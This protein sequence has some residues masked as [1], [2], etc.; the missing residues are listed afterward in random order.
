MVPMEPAARRGDAPL[1][2]LDWVR[3][4]LDL[5]S[6]V[7]E[8]VR[9]IRVEQIVGTAS[10]A[11][12]FDGRWRPRTS[13]LGKLLDDIAL[14]QPTGMDEPITVV[15][16]DRAYFVID[17]HKRVA[18]AHRTGREF[19]DA[20]VSHLPSPYVVEASLA[21]SAIM[22]T[23]RETEFRRHSRLI[24][25]VPEA[26]FA[27]TDPDA[28]GE[29]H[30]AVRLYG[31]QHPQATDAVEAARLWYERDYLPAVAYARAQGL[32]LID[33][34]TDADTYLA[35]H[36]QRLVLWGTECDAA[37][38]AADQVLAKRRLESARRGSFRDLLF[39]RGAPASEERLLL[40]LTDAASSGA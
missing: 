6:P 34:C 22:R 19:L 2:E 36:R 30:A 7:T 23:A 24:D 29:L 21:V 13:R 38:C 9:T 32:D 25:A 26:R 40:E 18:L 12:D 27:L 31:C 3:R 15:R 1:L 11:R 28:Y 33:R 39:R 37:E 35:V 17:G 5:G 10:R 8:G 20:N 14:A 4:Q 16:I